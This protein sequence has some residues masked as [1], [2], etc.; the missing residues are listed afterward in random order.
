MSQSVAVIATPSI[1]AAMKRWNRT[2]RVARAAA[3]GCDVASQAR[4]AI[5]RTTP[6]G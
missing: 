4:G 5:V 1:A 2:V 6:A 3:G